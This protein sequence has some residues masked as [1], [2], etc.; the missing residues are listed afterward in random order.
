MN[1]KKKNVLFYFKHYRGRHYDVVDTA[2][3]CV[4]PVTEKTI[5]SE[6][7]GGGGNIKVKLLEAV[8]GYCP[9]L[10]NYK[11][12]EFD[13]EGVDAVYLSGGF[14]KNDIPYLTEMD[15][16]GVF[17]YYSI[18][19]LTSRLNRRRLVREFSSE[20]LVKVLALSQASRKCFMNYFPELS[21]RVEVVYPPVPRGIRE[22][23]PLVD[24]DNIKFTFISNLFYAKGGVELA[25]AFESLTDSYRKRVSL[26]VVSKT[27][28]E[29]YS[30][31]FGDGLK[32]KVH[33]GLERDAV[34]K[35]L[36]ESDVLLHP[37]FIDSFG[38]VVL[39]AVASGL[40]VVAN[41]VFAIPEMVEDGSNGF[42]NEPSTSPFNPDYT[43]NRRFF[44]VGR[45][46]AFKRK[47]IDEGTVSFLKEKIEFLVD[48][49]DLTRKLKENS[50][51]LAEKRFYNK[52]RNGK[53]SRLISSL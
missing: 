15:N 36:G 17:T 1:A 44:G 30:Q 13:T 40:C 3:D 20:K 12:I 23:N 6:G 29:D 39:E 25:R 16:P 48:N 46:D 27:F 18:P 14:L 31:K 52:I 28:P 7:A 53:L 19:S 47:T 8:R 35:L 37:T 2:P 33:Y 24:E 50:L 49:P 32:L 10:I 45:V 26:T 43:I 5:S 9:F 4:N 42:L 11:E 51:K 21:G 34:F 22:S 41:S 38:V